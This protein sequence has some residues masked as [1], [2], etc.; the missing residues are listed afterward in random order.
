MSDIFKM[1]VCVYA[2]KEE[3]KNN[4]IIYTLCY[5]SIDCSHTFTWA[6]IQSNIVRNQ[7]W[8]KPAN[9]RC[10]PNVVQYWSQF[11]EFVRNMVWHGIIVRFDWTN[12]NLLKILRVM[13]ILNVDG[14]QKPAFYS[15]LTENLAGIC[16]HTLQHKSIGF[17]FR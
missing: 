13:R 1:C 14:D 9:H 12:G 8:M 5:K 17:L 11:H 6:C 2:L 7:K 3:G 10:R 16:C 4:E 15:W